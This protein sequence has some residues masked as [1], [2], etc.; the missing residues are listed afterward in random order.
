[1]LI[2]RRTIAETITK[3]V[4]DAFLLCFLFALVLQVD[5]ASA[6][7]QLADADAGTIFS[8]RI[9]PILRADNSS[10][11][12]ECHFAGVE[13][14]DFILDDQAK[15]FA[16]LKAKGMIDIDDPDQSK[17]LRFIGRK[18]EK[19]DA[20]IEKVRRQELIAFRSW[21]RAAVREPELLKATS[22]VEV[23][24]TLPPEVIRHARNDRVLASFVDNIWSEIG[25]C[26][27]CHSPD[28][29]RVKIGHDGLT[30]EDVDAISWV[31]PNDPNGTL[32]KL[33]DS[34]NIDT[35][36]P[37][38]SPVLTK[39][40]GIEEHGGGPK[41]FPGST[42]YR[43]FLRFLTDFAA[44]SNGAYKSP[45]DLPEPPKEITLMGGQQLRITNIPAAYSGMALQVNFYGQDRHTQEWSD[46]RWATGFGT[47]NEERLIWQS[48][49]MLAAPV[50]SQRAEEFRKRSLLLPGKY[51][52]KIYIDRNR[53]TESDPAYK[54]GR[55][56]F[57]GQ[58]EIDGLWK[59]GY[60]PP[61]IVEFPKL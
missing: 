34:G 15:T 50:N 12:T 49:I 55:Q 45:D 16:S 22:D 14:R 39:P 40:A 9:L 11:C 23:G 47:V 21:I 26:I 1:M 27:N 44:I 37:S 5:T 20:L 8:R 17:I 41:F 32:K 4:F 59:P 43:K 52:M 30:E 36:D 3:Y 19:P 38:E 2:P 60:Q 25:R 31:V 51:L 46:D 6:G 48:S 57:I 35:D 28:L 53:K 58:I 29:N 61:K 10:S 18:P 56:E 33:I 7:E 54:L 24:T 13:L 42:S